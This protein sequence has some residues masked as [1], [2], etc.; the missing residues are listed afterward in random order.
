MAQMNASI[1]KSN[2]CKS[3]SK[4][5]LTLSLVVFGIFDRPRQVLDGT[6]ERLQ[7]KDIT[8]GVG[9][10]ICWS[11]YRVCGSRY[12]FKIGNSSPTLETVAQYV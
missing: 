12:P 4:Q 11:I 2:T 10:L 9:S 3:S 7:R 1:S 8:D 6:P 5:H